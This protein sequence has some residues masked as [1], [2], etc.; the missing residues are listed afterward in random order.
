M[1]PKEPE[2]SDAERELRSMA[3]RMLRALRK[4][5]L[6]SEQARAMVAKR[7]TRPPGRQP[8]TDVERCPC[9]KSTLHR[10]LMRGFDC[11][12]ALLE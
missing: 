10:A 12:K 5:E 11:C 1:K 7:K 8:R 4:T 3:G 2:P 6:T 9:G